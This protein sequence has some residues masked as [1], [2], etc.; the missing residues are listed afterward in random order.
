MRYEQAKPECHSR[1]PRLQHATVPRKAWDMGSNDGARPSHPSI[2]NRSGAGHVSAGPARETRRPARRRWTAHRRAVFDI[3][4]TGENFR[5]VQELYR[6][7][8]QQKSQIGLTTVY[9]ILQGFEEDQV[10]E[11]QRA[12]D[13]EL[14]YRLRTTSEHCHYLLCRQCGRAESFTPTAFEEHTTEFSRVLGYAD[15]TH[16]IDLYG[17]CPRCRSAG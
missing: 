10:A 7:V 15:L 9:R 2:K 16:H 14:L 17:V 12:E 1:L 13:G 3:L 4:S 6:Q 8:Q 11:T 5:S